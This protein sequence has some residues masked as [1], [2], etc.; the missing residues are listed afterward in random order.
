MEYPNSKFHSFDGMVDFVD[1][2]FP[3]NPCKG[4][5]SFHWQIFNGLVQIVVDD[6]VYENEVE[7]P[8][9]DETEFYVDYRKPYILFSDEYGVCNTIELIGFNMDLL[10][11]PCKR[12][13]H[14]KCL[15]PAK[16]VDCCP[17]ELRTI[18]EYKSPFDS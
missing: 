12:I 15:I 6:I 18:C 4:K 5:I 11:N 7:L 3:K 17:N 1:T 14:R 13:L 2:R 9:Y 8:S 16:T 10:P